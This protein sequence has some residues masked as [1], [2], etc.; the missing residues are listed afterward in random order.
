MRKYGTELVSVNDNSW[1]KYFNNYFDFI[2]K[3]DAVEYIKNNDNDLIIMSWPDYT[4]P[5]AY[6]IWQNMR[7]S[8]TLIY[9]GEGYGGCTADDDFHKTV[10]KYEIK[11]NL[12][13]N[14]HAFY[15][16]HDKIFVYKK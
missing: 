13:E 10:Q 14:F 6:N 9:I 15:T 2:V 1:S 12:N 16:V 11:T 3:S 4:K 5:F 7:K 8:Q